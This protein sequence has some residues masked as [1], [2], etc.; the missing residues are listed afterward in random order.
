MP[1]FRRRQSGLIV[2]ESI[3]PETRKLFEAIHPKLGKKAPQGVA[4]RSKKV[5]SSG[6]IEITEV[7]MEERHKLE[8]EARQER[9]ADNKAMKSSRQLHRRRRKHG[10]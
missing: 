1:A 8:P 7:S 4:A 10:R 9:R 2:P 6:L 5:R 3:S